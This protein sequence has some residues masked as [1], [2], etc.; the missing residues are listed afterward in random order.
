MEGELDASVE[1][2]AEALSYRQRLEKSAGGEIVLMEWSPTMDLLAA[3]FADNSVSNSAIY[4][5]TNHNNMP[6]GYNFAWM[7]A[8]ASPA[9]AQYY[10]RGRWGSRG[11][12]PYI[13]NREQ[14][15]LAAC[16]E[17]SGARQ[18]THGTSMET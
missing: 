8:R 6:T 9:H 12:S 5:S 16:M 4:L 14:V 1:S 10:A 17:H 7:R 3:T 11:I 15:V 13:G 18:H 2:E